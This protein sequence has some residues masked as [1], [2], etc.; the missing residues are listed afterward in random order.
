[1]AFKEKP[2]I[3]ASFDTISYTICFLTNIVIFICTFPICDPVSLC[4]RLKSKSNSLCAFFMTKELLEN[5]LHI[6]FTLHFLQVADSLGFSLL[7][8]CHTF[9]QPTTDMVQ[10][11]WFIKKLNDY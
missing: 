6:T 9:D 1:M 8:Y 3:V 7:K 5:P 2:S 4:G 10:L 11:L